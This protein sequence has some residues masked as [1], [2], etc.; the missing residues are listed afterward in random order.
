MGMSNINTASAHEAVHA[1]QMN[2]AASNV[3]HMSALPPL[4]PPGNSL[5]ECIDFAFSDQFRK[6]IN[7]SAVTPPLITIGNVNTYLS[8]CVCKIYNESFPSLKDISSHVARNSNSN[9]LRLPSY[10]NINSVAK[11]SPIFQNISYYF[12]K[13]FI[14]F[15]E[16]EPRNNSTVHLDFGINFRQEFANTFIALELSHDFAKGSNPAANKLGAIIS[17]CGTRVGWA[18]ADTRMINLVK[19]LC[20]QHFKKMGVKVYVNYELI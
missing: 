12:F 8:S 5:G 20:I 7:S 3:F 16:N 19:N 14:P 4:V 18:N 1:A 10:Y 11:L 9:P 2:S 13:G 6:Y 15:A 17:C